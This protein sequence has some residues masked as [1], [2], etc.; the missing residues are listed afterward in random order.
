VDPQTAAIA[1]SGA[2]QLVIG[3]NSLI[4]A[5]I[6]AVADRFPTLGPHFVVA[7][8]TA[9]AHALDEREPGT[10]GVTELWLA[11]PPSSVDT[12]RSAL[13]RAPYDQLA[14][15]LRDDLQANLAG[16][17]LAVG[18]A[19]LLATD[20]VIGLVIAAVA[21]MLLVI[22]ER[23]D[24]AAELYAWESDGVTPAT[25]RRSMIA[26]AGAV[27]AV[28]V[29]GGIA[30]GLALTAFTTRLVA[31]TAVGTA[32]APPLSVAFGPGAV[33]LAV[34]ASVVACLLAAGLVAAVALREPIPR[35]PEELLT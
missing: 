8:T 13:A 24:D 2:L 28:G 33:G 22:A 31:V 30:I 10:G 12:L 32:P 20:A 5:R 4:P 35:R 15:T 14:V 9:L 11:A 23:R 34:A 26:R 18:A 19:R 25:L 3:G 29:P 6:V 17:P 16:D 7:A 27:V 21:V 1:S